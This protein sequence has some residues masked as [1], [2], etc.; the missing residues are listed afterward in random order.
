MDWIGKEDAFGDPIVQKGYTGLEMN[1]W[2]SRLG[3]LTVTDVI[4][5]GRTIS[6]TSEV[7]PNVGLLLDIGVLDTD[8]LS[9]EFQSF[10]FDADEDTRPNGL[11][12]QLRIQDSAG[13]VVNEANDTMVFV[14]NAVSRTATLT[15]GLYADKG[16]L[17]DHIMARMLAASG[18]VFTH[19]QG[20]SPGANVIITAASGTWT[21]DVDASTVSR[22]A[23]VTLGY[24]AGVDPAAALALTA[25]S[26]M[27]WRQSPMLEFAGTNANIFPIRRRAT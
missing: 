16:A 2:A 24:D 23:W 9:R 26:F 11:T 3:W 12:H 5:G 13:Y 7:V 21:T 15:H 17:L 1:M 25:P 10:K 6:T 14:H 19:N 22:R 27:M 20:A 8:L 18:I 4:D